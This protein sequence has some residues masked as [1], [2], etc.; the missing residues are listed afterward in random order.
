MIFADEKPFYGRVVWVRRNRS[1][2]NGYSLTIAKLGKMEGVGI[3]GGDLWIP[4]DNVLGR[5]LN[6]DEWFPVIYPERAKGIT[7]KLKDLKLAL[8][9]LQRNHE[10]TLHRKQRLEALHGKVLDEEPI[11]M[12]TGLPNPAPAGPP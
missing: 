2:G 4:F 9:R 11:A 10:A 12:L 8:T 7:R 3:E 1:V 6:T 5:A